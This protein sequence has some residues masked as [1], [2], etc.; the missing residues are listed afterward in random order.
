MSCWQQ[1]GSCLHNFCS[2]GPLKASHPFA[3]TWPP[4]IYTQTTTHTHTRLACSAVGQF[5]MLVRSCAAQPELSTS[6]FQNYSTYLI[7]WRHLSSDEQSKAAE[8][9]SPRDGSE[10]ESILADDY[11]QDCKRREW[12]SATTCDREGTSQAMNLSP[13]PFLTLKS[14]RGPEGCG[15]W[16]ARS[17]LNSCASEFP[18]NTANERR[19]AGT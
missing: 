12:L 14:P 6:E 9:K 7:H 16:K 1:D 17:L 10:L 4:K 11:K 2:T 8:I 13:S 18:L 5:N 15:K 3:L 19:D